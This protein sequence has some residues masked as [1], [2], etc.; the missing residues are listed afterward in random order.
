MP[1]GLTNAPAL[2]QALINDTLRLCLNRFACAY[3]DDIVV[4]S[5]TL[6]KHI[7][8]VQEILKQLQARRLYVQKE[9]CKFHKKVIEFLGFAIDRGFIQI[10]LKKVKS[11]ASWPE[12]ARLNHLQAFLGFANFYRRFIKDYSQRALQMTKLLKKVKVFQ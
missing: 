6:K 8:N 3:L 12:S 10:D 2:F 7:Q 5:R 9:K 11:V 4:Y 1:F